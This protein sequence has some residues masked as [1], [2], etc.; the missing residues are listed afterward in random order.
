MYMGGEVESMS[1]P[2]E[3]VLECLLRRRPPR[4]VPGQQRGYKG[5]RPRRGLGTKNLEGISMTG[6]N[7]N[8]KPYLTKF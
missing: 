2:E 6:W 7:S 3:G 8:E 4:G 1:M 5:H